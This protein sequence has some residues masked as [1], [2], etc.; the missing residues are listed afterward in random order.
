[1]G[2]TSP[3]R[4]HSWQFFCRIGRTSLLKV[5]EPEEMLLG[6]AE[7]AIAMRPASESRNVPT[8]KASWA[9]VGARESILPKEQVKCNG[10]RELSALIGG[11]PAR[12]KIDERKR[13]RRA[14]GRVVWG[15][16]AAVP[17]RPAR[18]DRCGGRENER[19][20][21]AR[22]NPCL[23]GRPGGHQRP[24]GL[25]HCLTARP[26]WRGRKISD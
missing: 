5:G 6:A 23:S 21:R 10:I 25:C 4:W 2:A 22:T 19:Q 1:M 26:R 11:R 3:G 9:G 15:R 8:R 16:R 20:R 12:K 13:R 14:G 24:P 18:R 7:A 17:R